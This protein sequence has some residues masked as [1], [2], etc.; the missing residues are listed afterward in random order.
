MSTIPSSSLPP[1]PSSAAFD[2][3]TKASKH[4]HAARHGAAQA[5]AVSADRPNASANSSATGLDGA[6]ARIQ[7]QNQASALASL[8][9]L[10]EA[11]AATRS[12]QQTILT[13]SNAARAAQAGLSSA[14]ALRVLEG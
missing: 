10:Q 13:Q 11:M 1:A 8:A 14:A 9:D 3:A 12:A 2:P 5:P 6:L 7:G 4:A